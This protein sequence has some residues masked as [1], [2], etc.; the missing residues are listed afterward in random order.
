MWDILGHEWAEKLLAGHIQRGEVR[1]AYLFAG[2]PGVGRRTLAL[3]FAQA[4]NCP[5]PKAPG[6]PCRQCRTCQQ[7]ERAQHIDLALIEPEKE[8]ASL[9]VEQ[10]REVLR[11]LSLLPYEA[12]Y[13][14][15]LFLRFQEATPS[16]QNALLKTLEEAPARVILLLTADSPDSLLPTIVSRCEVLRLRPLPAERLEKFLRQRGLEPEQARLLARISGGRLGQS[17]HLH[18]DPTILE[19]RAQLV[20]DFFSMLST[21]RRE[22]INYCELFGRPGGKERLRE[23]LLVWLSL[24]RDMLLA[25]SGAQLPLANADLEERLRA[26][27]LRTGLAPARAATAGQESALNGLDANLN[28]R[29]LAEVTLLD[30]PRVIA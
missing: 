15:A 1:H 12:P 9:K 26:A 5:T 14:V 21:S 19:R 6:Q 30:W 16:A 24:W 17:L 7:I 20:E 2:P 29:L 10:I 8:G 27:A 23:T 3:R 22:R 28:P 13:R 11:T 4:L 18:E 25:A